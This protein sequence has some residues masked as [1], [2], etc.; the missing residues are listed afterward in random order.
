MLVATSRTEWKRTSTVSF[1]LFRVSR[2]PERNEGRERN[3]RIVIGK[4]LGTA[5]GIVLYSVL[6]TSTVK[7]CAAVPDTSSCVYVGIVQS[8]G[9]ATTNCQERQI[10]TGVLARF[11]AAVA[12]YAGITGCRQYQEQ[13]Q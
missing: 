9:K 5:G 6:T 13:S 2:Y 11:A 12:A 7:A 8:A 1:M 10:I 4:Q 3:E